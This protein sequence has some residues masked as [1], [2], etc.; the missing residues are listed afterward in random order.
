MGALFLLSC[1]SVLRA[2]D[3]YSPIG[4]L[5]AGG[6]KSEAFKCNSEAHFAKPFRG[7]IVDIRV[8][9][10]AIQD[11]GAVSIHY[12]V[13]PDCSNSSH[14]RAGREPWAYCSAESIFSEICLKMRDISVGN[15]YD[16]MLNKNLGIERRASPNISPHDPKP[17]PSDFRNAIYYGIRQ[18]DDLQIVI[19]HPCSISTRYQRH[20][21]GGSFRG[22]YAGFE[23][24]G[25]IEGGFPQAESCPPQCARETCNSDRR[26]SRNGLSIPI[27]GFRDLDEDE[28]REAISGAVFVVGIFV[29]FAYVISRCMSIGISRNRTYQDRKACRQTGT[30]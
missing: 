30:D 14:W 12:I 11:Y 28:W 21:V 19:C 9:D 2:D 8:P 16:V 17:Q 13:M 6:A 1:N 27:K 15:V 18:K 24:C 20:C 4:L 25:L 10:A 23:I 3:F 22:C 5:G 26:E 29:I 7:Q